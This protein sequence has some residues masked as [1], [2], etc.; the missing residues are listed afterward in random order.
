MD[1]DQYMR[2]ALRREI[3]MRQD[4][5][6]L[7]Q[8]HPSQRANALAG[9]PYD[10]GNAPPAPARIT[11]RPSAEAKPP[12]P[13]VFYGKGALDTTRG[14]NVR[15]LVTH[16]AR[17]YTPETVQWLWPGRFAAGKLSLLGGAPGSGKSHL[18]ANLVA[19]VTTGGLWPCGEGRAPLG[20]A[21]IL[22]SE[23]GELDTVAP[24]LMA[25][26]AERERAT[27][28]SSVSIATNRRSF[29]LLADLD[30][31]EDAIRSLADVRLITIDPISSY[32]GGADGHRNERV[33]ELL[34]PLA[35]L[36]A[37]YRIA[38]VAVTHPPKGHSLDPSE[39][40]IG[41]IAFN[42]AARASFLLRP[43]PSDE[44]RRLFLQVKNNLA[45]DRGT[46]AF[47]VGEC[48]V[49]PGITSTR[50]A[51]EPRRLAVTVRDIIAPRSAR[52]LAKIEAEGFLRDLLE[53]GATAVADIEHAARAAGL[54]REGQPISQCR[55]LRDGRAA[56]GLVV[57]RTG[58]GTGARY[59][60]ALP[61]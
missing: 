59:T 55:A 22:S 9:L 33:R 4:M 2:D 43:D 54:L 50:I 13:R 20:R 39:H 56:L 57:K 44:T 11:R 15:R 38:V 12:K 21:I 28:I 35:A 49:V 41:S 18:V 52:A 51:W 53:R 36:A 47:R 58:F 42:A 24:R 29:S 6:R 37:R 17:D 10:D 32:L 48:E 7:A 61:Q 31:L 19:A 60:W 16:N 14:G 26:G 5:Q 8:I 25:A 23:D 40:F 46:L 45:R 30:L 34:D 3:I 1:D 27:I